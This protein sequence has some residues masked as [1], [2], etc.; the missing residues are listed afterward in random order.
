MYN[1]IVGRWME[2]DPIDFKA[3]DANLYRDVSNDPTNATDPSGLD[4]EEARQRKNLQALFGV[5]TDKD[6]PT[7]VKVYEEK[8]APIG[9]CFADEDYW[10][11]VQTQMGWKGGPAPTGNLLKGKDVKRENAAA[12]AMMEWRSLKSQ[13]RCQDQ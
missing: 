1:P 5:P 3:G 7:A 8:Q 4:E 9:L 12:K 6:A 10:S 13:Q 11:I 2:E